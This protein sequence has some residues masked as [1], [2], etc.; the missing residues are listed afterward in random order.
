MTSLSIA[1]TGHCKDGQAQIRLPGEV[2]QSPFEEIL[3][4]AKPWVSWSELTAEPASGRRLDRDLLSSPPAWVTW[5]VWVDS[6]TNYLVGKGNFEAW[7]TCTWLWGNTPHHSGCRARGPCCWHGPPLCSRSPSDAMFR[8]CSVGWARGRAAMPTLHHWLSSCGKRHQF[9]YPRQWHM[10]QS[11]WQRKEIELA[12]HLSRGGGQYKLDSCIVHH[13]LRNPTV[14]L[15]GMNMRSIL[16]LIGFSAIISKGPFCGHS[17]S[18][19]A[20][21]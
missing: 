4:R 19:I 15:I 2:V 9:G 10:L 7:L 6:P 20:I 5:D 11:N 21:V 14:K 12:F 8:G 16:L 18:L 3:K 1:Q 13:L 17:Q